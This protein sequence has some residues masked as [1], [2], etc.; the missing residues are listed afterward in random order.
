[1]VYFNLNVFTL[2]FWDHCGCGC[3]CCCCCCCCCFTVHAS[4]WSSLLYLFLIS[5]CWSTRKET[6][7]NHQNSPTKLKKWKTHV[8]SKTSIWNTSKSTIFGRGF[9]DCWW[10]LT[11]VSNRGRRNGTRQRRCP[12][13]GKSL[14]WGYHQCY[15]KTSAWLYID[16]YKSA[17]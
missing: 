5:G 15:G 3:C 2:S 14:V 4:K 11:S 1:M 7:L 6:Q 13:P 17:W 9:H 16:H 12:S 10:L 8:K